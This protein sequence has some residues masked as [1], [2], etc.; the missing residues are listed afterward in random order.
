M[1]AFLAKIAT[2]NARFSSP[3]VVGFYPQNG[4]FISPKVESVLDSPI[5][6]VF[7]VPLLIGPFW[8]VF[9]PQNGDILITVCVQ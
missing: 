4:G 2:G 5:W 1:N 9:I 7:K 6:R 8:G 3:K